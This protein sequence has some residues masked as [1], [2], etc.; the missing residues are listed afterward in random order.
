MIRTEILKDLYAELQKLP[1]ECRK[2]ME[3]VFVEGWDS[4]KI[5]EHLDITVSTV[6]NQKSRG[7]HLLRK[8]FTVTHMCY[9]LGMPYPA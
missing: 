8:R 6:K 4:K 5:A 1:P 3:L 2:V 7:I 9:I